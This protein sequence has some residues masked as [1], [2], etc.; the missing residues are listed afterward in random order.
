MTP[1]PEGTPAPPVDIVHQGRPNE[2]IGGEQSARKS[3]V[4]GKAHALTHTHTRARTLEWSLEKKVFWVAVP[5]GR[6]LHFCE[7]TS[8]RVTTVLIEDR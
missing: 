1:F 4:T 5:L 2:L 6:I 3:T 7:K 8:Q